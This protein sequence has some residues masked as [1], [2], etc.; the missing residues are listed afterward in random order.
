L[1]VVGHGIRHVTG[2]KAVVVAVQEEVAI[3]QLVFDRVGV[4]VDLEPAARYRRFAA[5]C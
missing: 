4:V 3:V 2:H 1:F 5:V